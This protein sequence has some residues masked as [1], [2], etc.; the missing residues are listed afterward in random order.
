MSPNGGVGH[1]LQRKVHFDTCP[2]CMI[3][4][5][6]EILASARL[7]VLAEAARPT[8]LSA[9]SAHVAHRKPYLVG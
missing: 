4:L 6:V 7:H 3:A 9:F 1:T 8:L 2:G 5:A